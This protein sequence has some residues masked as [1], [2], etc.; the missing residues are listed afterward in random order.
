[1]KPECSF[2]KSYADLMGKLDTERRVENLSA[3]VSLCVKPEAGCLQCRQGGKGSSR[4]LTG[5]ISCCED[6]RS[7][8]H[9]FLEGQLGRSSPFLSFQ[10]CREDDQHAVP[11]QVGGTSPEGC[12]PDIDLRPANQL[13][14]GILFDSRTAEL[15][16][17]L[18][19]NMA[20]ISAEI[21]Y[22]EC[23]SSI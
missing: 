22:C 15:S 20:R 4:V 2:D 9:P 7:S 23:S 3:I 14:I 10:V 5:C 17:L 8:C 1:M 12:V 18:H 21:G 16:I 19:R 6:L 13:S 11:L